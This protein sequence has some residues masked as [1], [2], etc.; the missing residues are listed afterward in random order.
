MS[1]DRSGTIIIG[2]GNEFRGD[3]GV[4]IAVA[5]LLR[6]RTS[7]GVT[8]REESGEGAALMEAW[9]DAATVILVDAVQSGATPGTIH[10]MD[11]SMDQVPS[12]F[13]HYSTHAFSV[14]EAVELA[15]AMNQ[16]PDRMILYGIEGESF[17]AGVLLSNTVER[18]V[19]LLAEKILGE[20]S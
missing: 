5:R 1:A 15:R 10:R 18:A 4:G 20:S 14:A 7:A 17:A 11:A 9:K 19:R 13:F 6:G 16:L 12:K 2:I 8:I 3:D